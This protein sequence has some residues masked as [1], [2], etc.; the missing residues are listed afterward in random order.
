MKE[1]VSKI[2]N[3]KINEY[4]FKHLIINDFLDKKNLELLSADISSLETMNNYREYQSAYGQ[5]KEWKTFPEDLEN[6]N[7][8]IHFLQGDIFINALSEKF[9]LPKDS[10]ISPDNSFDG[11]GYVISPP[12][13]FLGY[14]ADF[15]FSTSTHKFR[16]LNVLFYFN[17]DYKS[18][19][20]GRLHLLDSDSKTVEGSLE[21]KM[22][23]MLVF[24]TDDVSFHGVSKN[25]KDFYRRSF[26][27]YYYADKPLSSNQSAEPHKTIWVQQDK[28][29]HY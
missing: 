7:N 29:D 24:L 23:T 13:S 15:N 12:G 17:Q 25:S 19:F 2:T 26:N 22:N 21:P 3:A 28:H 5:K 11:G 18:E 1:L 6:L 27:L 20:G 14:H 8:W 9:N 16:V 10:K 4:P